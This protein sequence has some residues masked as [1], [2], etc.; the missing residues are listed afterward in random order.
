MN[1]AARETAIPAGEPRQLAA[2][3]LEAVIAIDRAITGRSRRGFFDKRLAAARRDPKSFIALGI[4]HDH[5]LTGF[6]LAHMLDGEF[7]GQHPVA[8]LDAIGVAPSAQSHGIGHALIERLAQMARARG[9]RELRTQANWT[10]HALLHFFASAGFQ[11][12]PRTI[13]TRAVA[14]AERL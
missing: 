10:D 3:D 11:L 6:A 13:L 1:H 8:A 2:E 7:G 12:A 9:A 4:D 14:S 5:R